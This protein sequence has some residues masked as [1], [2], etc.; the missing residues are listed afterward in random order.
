VKY[1]PGSG[2]LFAAVEPRPGYR[3]IVTAG[4]SGKARIRGRKTTRASAAF[5]RVQ[6]PRKY[7]HLI[8]GGRRA[9]APV[10]AKA[11]HSALDPQNRFFARAAAVAPH[12]VFGPARDAVERAS[13]IAIELELQKG[14]EE[15]NRMQNASA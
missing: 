5:G 7:L 12:P 1:Y 9:V 8:E 11:L 6:N 14:F 3:R 2:T 4:Q 15:F 13:Q 10:K